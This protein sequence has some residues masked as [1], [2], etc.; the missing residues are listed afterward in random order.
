MLLIVFHRLIV[1]YGE[2][3]F[4][5]ALSDSVSARGDFDAYLVYREHFM[6]TA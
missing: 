5:S 2:M 4:W 3:E 1:K 6:E